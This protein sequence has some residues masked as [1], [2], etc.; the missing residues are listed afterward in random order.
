[1][2]AIFS[3]SK[4]ELAKKRNRKRTKKGYHKYGILFMKW[5]YLSTDVESVTILII[6]AKPSYIF[7]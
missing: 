1:M 7:I 4:D 2:I 5:F 6:C 3:D